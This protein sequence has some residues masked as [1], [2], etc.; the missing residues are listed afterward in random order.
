MTATQDGTAAL[1]ALALRMGI[2]PEYRDVRGQLMRAGAESK[3]MLLAAMGVP[4]PDEAAAR[5]ALEALERDEWRHAL[6]PVIVLRSDDPAP[7]V[8]LALP[9]GSGS[10]AWQLSLE[11]GGER[12]GE[13]AF[14][15][16][17]RIAEATLDGGRI[18][19]RALPL[20]ADLP[21]GYHRL[22]V[23]PGDAAMLVIVTPGRC[24]LPRALQEGRRV[25][26]ISAQLYTMRSAGDWGIGDYGDLRSLVEIA[27]ARGAAVIGLNPLHA[28]FPDNPEHASPYSPASRLLLN[29]LNIDVTALPELPECR[30]ARDLL[31]SAE[32]R[33]R[34]AAARA[35]PL[36][37]YSAVTA[38]KL[39]MLE[40]LFETFRTVGDRKRHDAFA[41][42]RRELGEVLERSC[43][44][45]ALREHF[46]RQA[47]ELADWRSWP[48]GFR[49]PASPE[50][51]R[52]AEEHAHRL[53]FHVWLQW[54]ADAQ[55]GAAA[56]AAARH[57]MVV[58]LY[59]DLAVGADSAGAETWTD[60]KA[61]LS[62][63]Q[64]GAPRD[65]FNPAGQDWGLPPFHP[66]ALRAEGYRSFIEL[67]RANMRHAGGL[68]IDHVMGLLHLFCIPAGKK[69]A[70]G[71][72]I[73]YPIDDLVGIL[74]LESQRNRCLVVG[75]DLGTVPAGFRER[76]AAANILSYRI[77]FFE[78]EEDSGV[79]LRPDAYPPLAMA[80]VG[81]HDLPTLRGWWEGRDID[82]KERYG[83]L[84]TEEEVRWQ[85]DLRERD[86]ARLLEALREAGLLGAGEPDVPAISRA[87]HA[88][89]ARSSS[90]LAVAQLDDML[91]EGDQVNVPSTSWEH[92]NWR[93]K[94]SLPLEELPGNHGFDALAA[95]FRA[96]RGATGHG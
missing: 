75:E 73:A 91:D 80:V 32:F 63:V 25:W 45:L 77:L 31:A 72:Y 7:K 9:A 2:E 21:W 50:V 64:V 79:F 49:D 44:F 69:P 15:T 90:L 46:A 16:L 20:P 39:E 96:E 26:G 8:T 57:G 51:R 48:A 87:A 85:R 55:L 67:V 4:A 83:L 42:F 53:D 71:A 58:G 37:D 89:L 36:V 10:V 1:D 34:I 59:R 92:P 68:R 74:A 61:V 41:A 47:P 17:D 18:E 84:P 12:G 82:L 70:E 14:D 29:I 38:L 81:S 40:L 3:R 43:L 54:V 33:R 13:L 6:P 86:R 60:Q 93:R 56:E 27:A 5:A 52:F 62:G 76:M 22:R 66:R 94:L 30:S 88:F 95:L 78:Q 11:Q 24:W 65:I 23:T 35:K 28:L 19:R